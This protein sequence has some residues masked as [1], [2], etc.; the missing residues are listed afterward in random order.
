MSLATWAVFWETAILANRLPDRYKSLH[1]TAT[2][3]DNRNGSNWDEIVVRWNIKL[4]FFLFCR[5]PIPITN[6]WMNEWWSSNKLS[7]NFERPFY[8]SSSVEWFFWCEKSEVTLFSWS[9]GCFWHFW[10]SRFMFDISFEL[11]CYYIS[12]SVKVNYKQNYFRTK[13]QIESNVRKIILPRNFE[14]VTKLFLPN[15]NAPKT[16][17]DSVT[18]CWNKK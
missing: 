11:F 18:K 12:T 1:F 7:G 16:T 15:Q 10:T 14:R 13:R 3:K 9:S 8:L 6:E 4:D 2:T 17:S 5:K